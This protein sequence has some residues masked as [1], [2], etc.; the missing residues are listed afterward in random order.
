MKPP[1]DLEARLARLESQIPP[2]KPDEGFNL[3][4]LSFDE[5]KRMEAILE[6]VEGTARQDWAKVL[7]AEDLGWVERT[8]ERIR[9]P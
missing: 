3:D 1:R 5:L 9:V 4:L 6:R 7:S 2:D 8:S